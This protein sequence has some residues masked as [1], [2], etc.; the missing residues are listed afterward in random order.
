MPYLIFKT[1]QEMDDSLS[2]RISHALAA[3]LDGRQLPIVS[4][5][6]EIRSA[7]EDG[8]KIRNTLLVGSL[9][10]MLIAVLG[11]FGFVRDESNRRSKEIAIRKISGAT[12]SD[13]RR[14]L[15]RD[16]LKFSLLMAVAGCV[17]SYFVAS[18]MLEQFAEQITLTPLHFIVAAAAVLLIVCAVVLLCSHRFSKTN[19]SQLLR[20]E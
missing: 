17:A 13:V 8:R 1:Q 7:Y 16:V 5:E 19:P 2:M 15:L 12:S 4:W 9:F 20:N 18:K 11:L 6:E 10:A 3:T 14:L